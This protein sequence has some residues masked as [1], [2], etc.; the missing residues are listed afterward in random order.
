MLTLVIGAAIVSYTDG[1]HK[2]PQGP[3]YAGP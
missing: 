2:R 3:G 1:Y